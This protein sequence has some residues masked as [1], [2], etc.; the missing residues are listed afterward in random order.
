MDLET[1]TKFNQCVSSAVEKLQ[2]QKV[3]SVSDNQVWTG[4]STSMPFASNGIDWTYRPD[5]WVGDRITPWEPGDI[6]INPLVGDTTN[7][8]VIKLNPYIAT[9]TDITI[10]NGDSEIKI[11]QTLDEINKRLDSIENIPNKIGKDLVNGKLPYNIKVD[12]DKNLYYEFAVSGY[13]INHIKIIANKEGFEIK[14]LEDC[15][16]DFLGDMY[17]YISKGIKNGNQIE[18]IFI[19]YS[20]YDNHLESSLKNG[21]LTVKVKSAELQTVKIKDLNE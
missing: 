1:N 8:G 18:K 20:K 13:D 10:H 2:N 4:D 14:L 21:I 15:D 7:V 17:E 9:D 16:D 6:T 19:D 11:K 3:Y 12:F 5:P